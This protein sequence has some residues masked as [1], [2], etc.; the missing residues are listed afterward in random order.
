VENKHE[1]NRKN[2]DLQFLPEN[3]PQYTGL[4]SSATLNYGRQP[5]NKQQNMRPGAEAGD[6]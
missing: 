5:T 6:R 3:L 2:T 1:Y 4:T